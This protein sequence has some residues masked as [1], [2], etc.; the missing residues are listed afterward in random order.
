M[1]LDFALVSPSFAA[2]GSIHGTPKKWENMHGAIPGILT[3][4]YIHQNPADLRL[5]RR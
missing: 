1:L 2:Q 4:E 3:D 5:D